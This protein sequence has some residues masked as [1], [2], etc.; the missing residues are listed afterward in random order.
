MSRRAFYRTFA[1]LGLLTSTVLSGCEHGIVGVVD[2]SLFA[3]PAPD[4]QNLFLAIKGVQ[5][6]GFGAPVDLEYGNEELVDIEATSSTV[7]LNAQSIPVG[8]FKWVRIEIDPANSYVITTNGDRFPLDVA[9]PY[10]S[11]ADFTVGEGLTTSLAVAIDMRRALSSQ[12]KDGATVYTLATQ[13]RLVNLKASGALT[14][15]VEPDFMI[16]NLTVSDPSCD[17]SI[18]LYPGADVIPEGFFVH[19]AGGTSPFSSGVFVL[20]E[21]QNLFRF[22]VSLLP[23]GTYTAALTCSAADV[24]GSKSMVFTPTMDVTITAGVTSSLRF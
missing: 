17:P 2:L 20:H 21:P 11:T 19:V 5:L 12:T 4:L 24:P 3:T 18:Y 1:L 16:G 14:G 23:P 9:T 7:L 6:G 13:S 22:T 8:D 10:Q 15:I